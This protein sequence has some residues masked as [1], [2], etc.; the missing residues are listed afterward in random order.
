MDVQAPSAGAYYVKVFN[1]N[2][3]PPLDWDWETGE[4][5]A[6]ALGAGD[7]TTFYFDVCPDTSNETFEFWLYRQSWVPDVFLVVDKVSQRVT[8]TPPAGEFTS[9]SAGYVHTCGVRDD[10]SVACWGDDY[11]GQ[12]RPP[13]GEFSSVSAGDTYTCGVRDDGPIACW[14]SIARGLTAAPGG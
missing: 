2:L 14:G 6:R 12:A 3:L 5:P 9:V 13:A 4:S 8:A 10:G 7:E 11:Y 1:N